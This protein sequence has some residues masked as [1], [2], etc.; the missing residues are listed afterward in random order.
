M[1]TRVITAAILL[2]LFLSALFFLPNHWWAMFL[3]P[4]LGI[5][6]WEWGSL[7]GWSVLLRNIFIAVTLGFCLLL[8]QFTN[9]GV[10]VY[11][12]ALLFW[13][14][15]APLWLAKGWKIHSPWLLMITGWIVLVPLW[16]ALTR[17]QVQPALL[18]V[19]MAV[20]WI[21]DCFAMIAGKRFGKHKLAP[22]ISP[23]KT[24]EGAAGAFVGVAVY[25]LALKWGGMA[26]ISSLGFAAG[27]VFFAVL[28]ILGIEGDLFES[29]IKRNA[30]VKDSGTIFPGHG[31]MLDRLDAL[32]SSMPAAAL[33][34]IWMQ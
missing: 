19:L 33:L 15:I 10:P 22:S 6:A 34:L 8:W 5:G 11:L 18:L 27:V 23:G 25:Y 13:V 1:L 28:T 26:V 12:L 20:I 16:L 4:W 2:P 29:W 7:A 32:T 24:L 17:M 9:A 14:L 21:S 3:L 30:G 31:G